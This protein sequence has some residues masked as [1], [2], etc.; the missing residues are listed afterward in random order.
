[1]TQSVLITGA[2]TGI[3]LACARAAKREGFTV[4]AG[5]RKRGDLVHLERDGCIPISLDVTDEAQILAAR[6][7][8]QS[9][10]GEA[11]LGGLVNNAG[12]GLG[13]PLEAVKLDEIRQLFE[14]NVFGAL[15]VTQVFLPLIRKAAGRIVMMSSV[16]GRVTAPMAGPYASSKHA[17]ESFGDALRRELT[18]WNIG[19]SLVEPGAIATPIWD[20]TEKMAEA[21]EEGLS[22]EHRALYA[23]H[24]VRARAFITRQIE[25]AID[26]DHVAT[27]VMHALTAERPRARYTVGKDARLGVALARLLPDRA[28][29]ALVQRIR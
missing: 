28:L 23:D 3:G 17:L 21:V 2:S 9:E 12:I 25:N 4:F 18:P 14:V 8:V 24:L 26:P 11:G 19:V 5:A 16:S 22:D 20:K 15:R 7:L 1:M 13:G 29:D 6:D 10:V 27:A